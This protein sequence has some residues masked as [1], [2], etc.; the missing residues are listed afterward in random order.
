MGLIPEQELVRQIVG[1]H[2]TRAHVLNV[3]G[4]PKDPAWKFEVPLV[5]V[6]G[7]ERRG[8]IDL[9]VWNRHRP[10]AAVAM[11]VKRFKADVTGSGEDE[12]NKL[13]EFEKGVRQANRLAEIGFSQICLLI[14]VLVDSRQQNIDSIRAGKTTYEGMDSRLRARVSS[15]IST[16]GLA[17]RVSLMEI[18]YIQATDDRPIFGVGAS[19]EHIRRL[20]MAIEQPD[21]VTQRVNGLIPDGGWGH[22]AVARRAAQEDRLA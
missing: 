8:D 1:S 6:P 18:E 12:V 21:A 15:T 4:F 2:H 16:A 11:E 22:K 7:P 9:L 14:L 5:T 20:E 3:H 10:E 19:D 13:K 17:K